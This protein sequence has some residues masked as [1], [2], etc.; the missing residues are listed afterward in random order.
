MRWCRLARTMGIMMGMMIGM[1]MPWA[2]SSTSAGPLEH[3]DPS[4]AIAPAGELCVTRG[5]IEQAAIT[6]PTVRAF[7]PTSAGDAA[8]LA[9]TFR[10][11]APTARA[12]A[13]GQDRRQVGLKL[14]A[15]DGCNVVYVMWRLDPRPKLEV[16]VKRNA[17]KRTHEECGADGYTKVKP[18]HRAAPVPA[19]VAGASHTLR[20]EIVGDELFAWIDGALA[21]QGRLPDE[22]RA[23]VGPAGL[24]TD[25]L[26]LADLELSAAPHAGTATA[27]KRGSTTEE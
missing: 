14:R 13:N 23:L 27:C 3:R 26:E 9:F 1:T 17:G 7:A 16:S 24:R 10:G 11:D 15:Q 8:Q 2:C 6:E 12:L 20:A 19:L 22:A 18:S 4:I 25:N 21:W 5:A